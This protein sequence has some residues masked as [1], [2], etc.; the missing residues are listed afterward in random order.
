[1]VV[2]DV[3]EVNLVVVVSIVV[4]DLVVVQLPEDDV[5]GLEVCRTP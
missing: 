1:M 2:L 4:V 3:V 5:V